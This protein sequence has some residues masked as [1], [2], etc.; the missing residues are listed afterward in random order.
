MRR[1]VL[2]C[3]LA[4]AAAGSGTSLAQS[5][6]SIDPLLIELSGSATNAVLT[7]TNP[8]SRESRFEIKAF[9]WDQAAD[10]QP[11]LSATTEI[12]VF[13]PLVTLKARSTQRIRVGTT[14]SPGPVEKAYRLMIEELPSSVAPAANTVAM[15]TR[16]GLPIFIV[17]NQPLRKGEIGAV[18]VAARRV[19]V[20]LRNTGNVHA[21]VDTVTVRGMSAP[22]ESVWETDAR[23]WYVLAGKTRTF[24]FDF[25]PNQCRPTKYLE[26][27]VYA[28]DKVITRRAEMPPDACTP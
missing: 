2:A 27:E 12:V 23:G 26:I 19:R 10:G 7:L 11:A 9:A 17:P 4:V 22:D 16:V 15:R 14:A 6:F 3:A 21:I 5:S 13:P 18:T 28:H 25:K 24:E 20:P 1:I 8:T